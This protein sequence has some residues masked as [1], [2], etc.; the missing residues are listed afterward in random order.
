MCGYGIGSR[1]LWQSDKDMTYGHSS[2]FR[3]ATR[4]EIEE[5]LIAEGKRRYKIGDVVTCL[6]AVVETDAIIVD[7]NKK[8]DLDM[9]GRLWFYGMCV[10]D[11]GQWAE[12]VDQSG[13]LESIGREIEKCMITEPILIPKTAGVIKMPKLIK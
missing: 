9:W 12:I 1:G 3:E 6:S 13:K 8:W 7:G 11:K 2:A 10:F 4:E 5:A